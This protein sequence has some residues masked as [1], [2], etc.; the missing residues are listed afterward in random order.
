MSLD[1]IRSAIRRHGVAGTTRLARD[2]AGRRVR[3]LWRSLD[4]LWFDVRHRVDTRGIVRDPHAGQRGESYEHAV[5]YQSVW[6]STFHRA[7]ETD[8]I[9]DRADYAFVDLGC[10]KGKAVLLAATYGFRRVIGVELSPELAEVAR[11]NAARFARRRP[12][13]PEAEILCTDAATYDFPPEPLAIY[14]HNPFDEVILARVAASLGHSL[15]ERPRPAV[16]IYHTPLHRQVL[17][18]AAFLEE[19]A[20]V[21]G[22]VVYAST[23]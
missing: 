10:G 2:V 3:G 1:R 20:T 13:L 5:C 15:T 16:V 11:R 23:L 17:D 12:Q 18:D 19:R 9:D 6:T 14:L 8:A 21:P 22:G 4:E 7:M